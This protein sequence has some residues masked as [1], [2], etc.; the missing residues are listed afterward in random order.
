MTPTTRASDPEGVTI[1]RK[2]PLWGLLT[3]AGGLLAAAAL[4]WDSQN[5]QAVEIRHLAE[6]TKQQADTMRGLTEQIRAMADQLGKKDAIDVK[7]DLR[8]DEL[9]RRVLVVEERKGM[10]Q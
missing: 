4:V 10:R 5:L 3:A 8:I 9:E 7:Q 2:L 1:D 6:Q